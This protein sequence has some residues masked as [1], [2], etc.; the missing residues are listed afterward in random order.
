M[1]TDQPK[2]QGAGGESVNQN[3]GEM[4]VLIKVYETSGHGGT[5]LGL[6]GVK[7]NDVVEVLGVLGVDPRL[8]VFQS[9]Q[10]QEGDQV[11]EEDVAELE[12]M[13]PAASV[14][15]YSASGSKFASKSASTL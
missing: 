1:D 5:L 3:Q 10:F 9:G 12:A 2:R 15:R 8:A 7:L 11:T 13:E 14:N 4:P 6:E